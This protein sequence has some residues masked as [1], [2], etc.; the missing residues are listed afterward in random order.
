[1]YHFLFVAALAL[2]TRLCS[3]LALPTFPSQIQ[4]AT[5]DDLNATLNIPALYQGLEWSFDLNRSST[6]IVPNTAPH[7]ATYSI[8]SQLEGKTATIATTTQTKYFDLISFYFGCSQWPVGVAEGCTIAVTGYDV[9]GNMVGEAPFV[10]AV[11]I[12]QERS[13]RVPMYKAVLP[14]SFRGLVNATVLIANSETLAVITTL[15]LDSVEH[16]NYSWCA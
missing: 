5:F 12:A 8:A 1:M 16:V 6:N 11:T 14:D 15:S 13:G 9:N 3:A 7:V 4:T 10:F 2:S